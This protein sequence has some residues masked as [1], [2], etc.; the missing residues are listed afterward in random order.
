MKKNKQNMNI[1]TI[2]IFSNKFSQRNKT[3]KDKKSFLN[4]TFILQLLDKEFKNK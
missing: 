2:Q 3:S 4:N 1:K